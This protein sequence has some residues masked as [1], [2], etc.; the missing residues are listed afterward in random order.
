MRND[1]V[2]GMELLIDCKKLVEDLVKETKRKIE[3]LYINGK[4]TSYLENELERYL[5]VLRLSE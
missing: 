5:N 2:E 4:D 3:L 1:F